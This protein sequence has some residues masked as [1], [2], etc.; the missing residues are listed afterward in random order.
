MGNYRSS[1]LLLMSNGNGEDGGAI[2]N[3]TSADTLD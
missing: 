3:I 2:M 1:N